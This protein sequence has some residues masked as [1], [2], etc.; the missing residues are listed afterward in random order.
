MCPPGEYTLISP[1]SGIRIGV[2]VGGTFVD[3]IRV[4]P[5]GELREYKVLATPTDLPAAIQTGL[6]LMAAD[7]GLPLRDFVSSID[8][9]VHGTTITTNAVLTRTG[10]RAGLPTTEGLRDCLQMRKSKKE[11]PYNLRYQAPHR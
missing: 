2:D 4:T 11:E 8:R 10:S 1:D 3:L 6:E 9:I 7:A 5:S